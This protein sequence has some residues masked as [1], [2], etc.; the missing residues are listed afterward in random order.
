MNRPYPETFV[1]FVPLVVK[2]VTPRDLFTGLLGSDGG[3][4]FAQI[5]DANLRSRSQRCVQPENESS[6]AC[7]DLAESSQNWNGEQLRCHKTAF[8][9]R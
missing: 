1:I 5:S 6:P 7:R 4:A 9:K 8:L 3:S 2:I